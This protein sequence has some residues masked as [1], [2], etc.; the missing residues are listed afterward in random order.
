MGA[1]GMSKSLMA[2]AFMT[3]VRPNSFEVFNPAHQVLPELED[4]TITTR[5]LLN[6]HKALAEYTLEADLLDQVKKNPSQA[7]SSQEILATI[8]KK[9]IESASKLEQ[10]FPGQS[11][12]IAIEQIASQ[13][14]KQSTPEFIEN[15]ILTPLKSKDIFVWGSSTEPTNIA[16][17]WRIKDGI[18]TRR[19][20]L[21]PITYQGAAAGLRAT[22][23]AL[24]QWLESLLSPTSPVPPTELALMMKRTSFASTAPEQHGYGLKIWALKPGVDGYGNDGLSPGYATLVMSVPTQQVTVAIMTNNETQIAPL[25][26]AFGEALG[27]ALRPWAPDDGMPR[28][29]LQSAAPFIP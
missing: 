26:K 20:Q 25:L 10:F 11:N 6:N 5:D 7:V 13:L 21:V 16:P 1:G 29:S 9:P 8:Y 2:A 14:S 22:P 24:A 18:A 23:S 28:F 3:L 4:K 19:D 27:L 15:S 17:G 12:A